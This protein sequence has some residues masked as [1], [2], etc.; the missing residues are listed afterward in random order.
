MVCEKI[1]RERFLE[2][3]LI[4]FE[5]D[6]IT[7]KLDYLILTGSFGRNEPTFIQENDT[8]KYLSDLE[9]IF[10][11]KRKNAFSIDLIDELNKKYSKQFCIEFNIMLFSK[12]RIEKRLNYNHTLKNK[13]VTLLTYDVF[14]GSK[15]IIGNANEREDSFIIDKYEGKKLICNRLAEWYINKE[16]GDMLSDLQWKSKIL[17]AVSTAYLVF[18]D[19]Y[20]SSYKKQNQLF[21][22]I[23]VLFDNEQTSIINNAFDFLRVSGKPYRVTEDDI[24][25]IIKIFL[26]K[27]DLKIKSKTQRLVFKLKVAKRAI[28]KKRLSYAFTCGGVVD[29]I[30][31]NLLYSFLEQDTV[32]FD[33]YCKIWKELIY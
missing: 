33:K 18:N 5:K 22:E 21:N 19:S 14:K 11:P 12:K 32:C 27:Y 30:Y 24:R 25:K 6:G 7:E 28:G 29:K 13:Y 17:L 9:I 23:N 26:S 31:E 15:F 4:A 1:Y 2:E 16:N 20:A 8:I 3:I 10:A